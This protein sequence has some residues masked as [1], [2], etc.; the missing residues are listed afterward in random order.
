MPELR[1]KH[2]NGEH[3]ARTFGCERQLF[4]AQV[5]LPY[6]EHQETRVALERGMFN[7]AHGHLKRC[8]RGERGS[9]I[10]LRLPAFAR[11][12][13]RRTLS[14]DDWPLREQIRLQSDMQKQY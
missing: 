5:G 6:R 13:H 14:L 4:S 3:D 1:C 9:D 10:S 8:A 12:T 7:R 2:S 11:G